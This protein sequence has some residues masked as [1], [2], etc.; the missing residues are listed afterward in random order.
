[1]GVGGKRGNIVQTF[2]GHEYFYYPDTMHVK[3]G[4]WIKVE[5]S[6]SDTNPNNNDGQGRAG[7]DRHNLCP[8]K[9]SNY[10]TG[11]SQS[12]QTMT[13]AMGNNYPAFVQVPEG[14]NIPD[15][16]KGKDRIILNEDGEEVAREEVTCNRIDHYTAPMG[17]MTADEQSALCTG[18]QIGQQN[19]D[20]GDME[21][22]D[23]MGTNLNLPPI[24]LSSVG[25]WGF[26]STRNNN[27]SN[28]SE[29]GKLCVDEGQHY[30]EDIGSNGGA[31][32]TEDGW[33]SFTQ[34]TLTSIY[35]VTFE[36]YPTE[37]SVSP[38][39]V[40]NPEGM[41]FQ[42]DQKAEL[43]IKY[44]HRALR[45]PKVMFKTHSGSSFSEVSDAEFKKQNGD[46]VAVVSIS[47]SGHYKVQDDINV[48]AVAG[49]V[50]ALFFMLA[51]IATAVYFRCFKSPRQGDDYTASIQA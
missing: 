18:R 27:F 44:T 43:G 9:N 25:C 33:V 1:M 7:T 14:Y 34:D 31:V 49:I 48:G 38:L 24:Q 11:Y 10:E 29:K 13:G 4:D 22:L 50:I 20:Y 17:G 41:T 37:D 21:E 47:Q 8:L 36:S 16:T 23:D 2:P 30:E 42:D 3:E 40:I 28:R 12:D 19:L 45:S 15:L 5:I 26:V 6:G 35:S 46:T 39:I 51:A 32:M